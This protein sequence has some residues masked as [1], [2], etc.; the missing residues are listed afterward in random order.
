MVRQE[1]ERRGLSVRRFAALA[2]VSLAYLLRIE[3]GRR[4]L[5]VDVADRLEAALEAAPI[6]V[7]VDWQG[8]RERAD[9]SLREVARRADVDP[10]VLSRVERGKRRATR[11]VAQ[12]LT[13]VF[14]TTVIRRWPRR[15]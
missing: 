15:A 7:E 14:G 6:R 10:A 5:S 9:L 2:G 1:R 8:L 11:G 4:R 3:R 13:L 12:R